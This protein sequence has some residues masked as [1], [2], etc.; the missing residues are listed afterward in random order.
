VKGNFV[1]DDALLVVKDLYINVGSTPII[2]AVS[3]DIMPGEMV[4]LVG[5]SGSGK[6]VT[7]LSIMRLLAEPAMQITGGNIRFDGIDVFA[8]DEAALRHLRGENIAMIFQEP[9]TSLNPVF[10]IG[11]QIKEMILLHRDVSNRQASQ[12]AEALLAR[13]GIP[14]PADALSR[15]PHQL[16]G[17]QRQRVM[18][19]IALACEPRLLIADE[20]TTALDVTVQ[21]QILGLI[22]DLRTETGMAVM[23]ITHDLGVVSQHCDK[24]AV[25]YCGQIVEFA[26]A[27]EL[28]LNPQH[29]YT[30]ALMRTIPSNNTPGD[31]L[32]AISGT[33]PEPLMRPQ[34]CA[35]HPRCPAAT[36]QCRTDTPPLEGSDHKTACW[37][38]VS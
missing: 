22:D 8:L 7:A 2:K 37:N 31:R 28:F 11:Q 6:S 23:L 29:R 21:A 10:T 38:P 17:G 12:M 24:V 33:V 18:I 4:G 25:M 5:E 14:A 34:G 3:L 35:F 13:V 30:E 32:P 26:A 27:D 1:Q 19:A 36:Q 20:P 9:M 15:Y 16:S